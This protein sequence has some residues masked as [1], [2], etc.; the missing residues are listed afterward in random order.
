MY[1]GL[2]VGVVIP[3]F[4]EERFISQT[5]QS[6]PSLVDLISVIDDASSDHTSDQVKASQDPRVELLRHESNQGVGGAILSGY[7]HQLARGMDLIVVMGGDGQMDPSDMPRLL[8]PLVEGTA[9]Y[10]KGNRLLHKD[11]LK[12]MPTWR[13]VGN[14]ALSFLTRIS[15]GYGHILDSQ[16]GYTAISRT[17]LARIDTATVYRRY[18]FPNDLLAH[19]NSCRATVANV[20][21]RPIYRDEGTGISPIPAVF[22]LSWVLARSFVMRKQRE[23][24]K[25][26]PG[27]GPD[28]PLETCSRSEGMPIHPEVS[29]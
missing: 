18:G 20:V 21:V 5:I 22:A 28:S 6:V 4:N 19:L 23:G 1:K 3:A 15:S 26:T 7:L 12:V 14:L 11:V 25:A 24:Q 10:V 2:S 29:G 17:T 27:R 8:E 16:C 9:D 13:L